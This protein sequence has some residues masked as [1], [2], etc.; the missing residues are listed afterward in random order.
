MIR[1][2]EGAALFELKLNLQLFSE[3]TEQAT[4]KKKE[5]ARKKGQVAVTK[6]L[7]TAF[8]L[9][10][11]FFAINIASGY[12]VRNMKTYFL[13][14]FEIMGN[15]DILFNA[16]GLYQLYGITVRTF[17]SLS[18][19]FLITAM[20]IGIALN[21]AQ[22]GFLFTVE[23][24][25]PKFEKISP[26]SGL[27]RLFSLQSIAEL[28]KSLLKG[29]LVIFIVWSYLSNNLEMIVG[30]MSLEVDNAVVLI[31]RTV[32]DIVLRICLLLVILGI[33]D[34][35]FKKWQHNK[36]LMMSKQE[37]KDEYKQSEGDPQLKSKIKEKQRQI[38][39]GRMMQEVPKADVIITNPTHFAVAL[40]YNNDME[41]APRVIAKGQDLIAMKIKS[42]AEENNIAIIENKPL[43]RA[44]YNEVDIGSMIPAEFFEAVAETLA[45][46]YSLKN[47]KK[48]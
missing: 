46:V 28:L 2:K 30:M 41:S 37:V 33:A 3:K 34:F 24:L 32:F 17:L 23:P 44:L 25:I 19:P 22:V 40:R 6:D 11:T 29:S 1:E 10:A 4:T 48:S 16:N 5:D 47:P 9:L 35:I 36:K 8:A 21:L 39:M 42:V 31:W 26:I 45:Y 14:I 27:K 38:A 20:V 15:T 43:A 18:L 7:G 13:T 12:V